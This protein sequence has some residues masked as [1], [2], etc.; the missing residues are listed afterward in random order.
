[1]NEIKIYDFFFLIYLTYDKNSGCNCI[2]EVEIVENSDNR[3][4]YHPNKYVI[5]WSKG[6]VLVD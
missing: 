4:I 1:M 5:K 3:S 2:S 6:K